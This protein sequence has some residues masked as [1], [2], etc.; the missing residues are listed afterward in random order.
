MK[1]YSR[2]AALIVLILLVL[3]AGAALADGELPAD[4]REHLLDA[5]KGAEILDSAHWGGPGDGETRF[6]L[7]RMKDGTNTLACYTLNGSIWRDSFTASKAVPQG[8][9]RLEIDVSGSLLS[10]VQYDAT[11]DNISLYTGYQR[12]SSGRWNL[13]RIWSY[14]DYESMEIGDGYITYYK[15]PLSDEV[16][17]TVRGTFQ[18]DLRYVSL[19]AVPKNLKQ[20][21]KKLTSAP[22][23]PA[24]SE[25][26][27]TE[28]NFTG[29]KKYNVY[30]APDK[31]S[32][33][34]GNGKAKVSTNSWIQVFGKE[35]GWILIQYSID[36]SHYR[37]GY[38]DAA[39]LPKKAA[40]DNLDLSRFDA[41]TNTPVSVTDDPLYSESELTTLAA[42]AP[43]T[44]LANMGDWAYIE[45]AGFRGFVPAGSLTFPS[46]AGDTQDGWYVFT[47]SDGRQYDLFEIRK[48]YYDQNHKVY[49]VAGVY[50]R[51]EQNEE[52]E[53]GIPADDGAFTYYLAPGFRAEMQSPSDPDPDAFVSVTDL[54]AWYIDAYLQGKAPKNGELVFEC[55][56]SNEEAAAVNPDFWF[57]T[58]RIRLNDQNQIEA[59]E[60]V[61]VPWG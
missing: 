39:S 3:C 24:D 13:C 19:D 27:A 41:V 44:W 6:V 36:S 25:L 20:A 26:K 59:M 29:G 61:Y 43:V 32:L 15:E 54:Y 53:S 37:F 16:K 33:R 51:I 7:L 47:G 46:S 8:K 4:F 12:S 40:V 57:V 5:Y 23:L 34:G 22:K 21:R 42:G 2:I 28:I 1:K 56:L 60:S 35:N 31:N 55:D 58:T 48:M 9:Y 50:E 17:G 38:I 45:G 49:A 30:S 52:S 18:R 11:G 14:S 10:I